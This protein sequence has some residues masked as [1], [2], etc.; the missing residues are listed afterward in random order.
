V[1]QLKILVQ[2]NGRNMHLQGA[3]GEGCDLN[4]S[5]EV[6]KAGKSTKLPARGKSSSR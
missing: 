2:N 1:C 3:S 5:V 4:M 6:T